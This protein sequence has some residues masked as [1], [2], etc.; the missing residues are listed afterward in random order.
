MFQYPWVCS[1]LP[2][3]CRGVWRHV[4]VEGWLVLEYVGG[5]QAIALL[6]RFGRSKEMM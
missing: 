5:V 1:T 6:V 4:D 2:G 3:G